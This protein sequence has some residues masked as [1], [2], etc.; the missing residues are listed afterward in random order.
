[1]EPQ[2]SSNTAA[3]KGSSSKTYFLIACTMFNICASFMMSAVSVALPT[4]NKEFQAN[5]ILL[6]WVITAQMLTVGVLMLPMGRLADIVGIKKIYIIGVIIFILTQIASTFASSVMMLLITLCFQGVGAAMVFGSATAILSALYP[7]RERGRAFGVSTAAV[8]IGMSIGPAVG[9]LLIENLGWRSIFVVTVPVFIMVLLF[10][11]WKIR[12]EWTESRGEKFDYAGAIIYGAALVALIYG[13]SVLPEVTGYILTGL[14]LAGLGGFLVWENRSVTP[15]FDVSV[16]KS[17]RVFVFSNLT[18]LISYAAIA[19]IVFLLSLYL[20][21]IKGLDA[22]QAGLVL[23]AQPVMQAV[24]SPY[25]GRL[26][27]KKEP[28]VI[29][30]L[31]MGLTFIGLLGLALLN[32][33]TP[34]WFIVI[35]LAVLGI[36]FGLFSSPNT[37]AI[38]GSVAPKHYGV[39][40][41][42][43]GTMRSIG[44][45]LCMG[46]TMVVMSVVIGRVVISEP[47]YPAFLKCVRIMFSVCT[48]LCFAG[49]FTS[50]ARGKMERKL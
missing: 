12:G 4:I 26:S 30:S 39:A 10:V 11:L 42:T 38:M 20:Q 44:Q 25:S 33:D 7:A 34:I 28:R 18:A 16:F 5:A 35:A 46:G 41:A 31:G 49:I 43:M 15:M 19:C 2:L 37:N 9:G 21:Y 40:S 3:V 36:G 32:R 1:L 22:A 13:L 45:M 23:V 48:I 8:Y 14:G 27:D 47:Y 29:A 17:N 50:L 24:F 6:S